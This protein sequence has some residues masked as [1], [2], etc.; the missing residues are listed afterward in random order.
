MMKFQILGYSAT[1]LTTLGLLLSTSF[2]MALAGEPANALLQEDVSQPIP[3]WSGIA[4]GE[5]G[6]IGEEHDAYKAEPNADPKKRI[7]VLA[8]VSKPT[9]TVYRPSKNL[10]KG[11]GVI[12]CPGGG[13]SIL[14]YDL[15]GSEICKWLNSFG[16]TGFLLKYRVPSRK[17][18][19]KHAASLQDAQRAVS[20]VRSRAKE[21]GVAPNKIGILGFSAGGHLS[22]M[23]SASY[24]KRS[25]AAVDGMDRESCRPDFSILIYPA[26]LTRDDDSTKL[27]PE[28]TVTAKTPP[29]F[30]V[31]SQD[32]PVKVE[33]A[34][35]YAMAL[36]HEKVPIEMHIYPKGGHGYGLREGAFIAT[37]WPKRAARWLRNEVFAK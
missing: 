35:V 21:W 14:A 15:E 9:L 23:T 20:I 18:L 3:L 2:A 26:Y 30:I 17:G 16:V 11:V 25:Y 6:D 24:D 4:P 32:D 31:M 33:C 28:I 34:L 36:Q 1:L 13:Y 29:A 27:A 7:I 10:D 19:E 8:N 22:V 5:K 37:D 12:V